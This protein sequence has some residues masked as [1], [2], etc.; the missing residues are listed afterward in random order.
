MHIRELE[1]HPLRYH[2][3]LAA[4]VYEQQIFLPV[5][6]EAE[7]VDRVDIADGPGDRRDA[8]RR[9]NEIREVCARTLC[10]EH[11]AVARL[12]RALHDEGLNAIEGVGGNASAVA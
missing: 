12:R 11:A 3:L 4:G 8:P 7:P 2:P 5:V 1:A 6:I 10:D 9:R